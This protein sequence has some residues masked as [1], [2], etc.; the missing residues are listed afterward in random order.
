ML[1]I[2][3]NRGGNTGG[4]IQVERKSTTGVVKV[5]ISNIGRGF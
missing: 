5:R 4:V 1:L 2:K 3:F